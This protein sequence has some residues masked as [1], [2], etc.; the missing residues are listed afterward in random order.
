MTASFT[1][2]SQNSVLLVLVLV[3]TLTWLVTWICSKLDL[4]RVSSFNKFC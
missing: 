1:K 3:N 2:L 4:E